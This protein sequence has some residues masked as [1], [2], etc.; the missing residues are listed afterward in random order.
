[1]KHS[2][3]SR[4]YAKAFFAFVT[5][6]M[7]TACADTTVAPTAEVS[8]FTAPASFTKV[9]QSHTFRVSNNAGSTERI[10]SHV[11]TIPAGAI[12]DPETS[13]YGP[14]QWD[15]PCT[16]LAGS[17]LITA[18]VMVGE[19]NQPYVDFQPALRFSPSKVVM[20]FLRN[21]RSSE[22]AQLG[23]DYCNN[24]GVCFDESLDDASLKPFRVGRTSMIGR[25]VKHFSGYQVTIGARCVGTLTQELDGTWMCVEEAMARRSGYMVASGKDDEDKDKDKDEDKDEDEDEDMTEE[26]RVTQ[27]TPS[28]GS[29]TER[30]DRKS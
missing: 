1:M 5:I 7:A 10:G 9:G 26:D 25:R 11:I 17:I 16:P 30:R 14:T 27:R 6:G 8:A 28:Q 23:V 22:P 24:L 29:D 18:T 13:G 2:H 21:G 15:K 19:E 20:L 4:N 12:C 3:I